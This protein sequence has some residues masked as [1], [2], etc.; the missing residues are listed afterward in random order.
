MPASDCDDV[1]II[2]VGC[3]RFE[4]V[5]VGRYHGSPR[6]SRGDYER[7]DYRYE[8]QPEGD[9]ALVISLRE[10]PWGP[11]YLR[12]GLQLATDFKEDTYFN[13]LG[14]YRRILA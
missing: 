5:R 9:R 6:F 14:S 13:V 7:I 2:R 1:D 8:D 11:G 4:I 12:F 3:Q 10:K